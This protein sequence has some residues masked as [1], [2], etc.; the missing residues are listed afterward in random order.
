MFLKTGN[1]T[2]YSLKKRD[3]FEISVVEK[4]R[5]DCIWHRA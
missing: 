2:K 3:D 5:V 1:C 4:A